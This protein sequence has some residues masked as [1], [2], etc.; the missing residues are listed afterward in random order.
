MATENL[1][2]DAA[3][4]ADGYAPDPSDHPDL[5]SRVVMY[6]RAVESGDRRAVAVH[7]RTLMRFVGHLGIGVPTTAGPDNG[8][9]LADLQA[10]AVELGLPKSGTK[11]QLASRI[12]EAENTDES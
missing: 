6:R 4:F 7:S 2:R 5:E 10:R 3:A 1:M 8:P 11:A 12:A 9:T